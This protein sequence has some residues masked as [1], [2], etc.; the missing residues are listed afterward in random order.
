MLD[1]I[2]RYEAGEMDYDE[3]LDFFQRL[4]HTGLAWKLQGH[5]GRTATELLY[6]GLITTYDGPEYDTTLPSGEKV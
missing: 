1:D 3:A 2:I 6:R 4:V 5:Y